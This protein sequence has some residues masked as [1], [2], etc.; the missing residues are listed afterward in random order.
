M[1]TNSPVKKLK[2][3]TCIIIAGPTA[4]GKTACAIQL[5]QHFKTQIISADSRQCFKELHIGVAKP[6]VEE[7]QAVPHHFI[8]SHS[9]QDEVNA[10]VFEQYAL[11]KVN[12]ILAVNDI[13]VLVGGTGLYIKAFCEG[14]D[15][16]P[17]ADAAVRRQ[18][19]DAY[20]QQGIE[21]LQQQVAR[22]D[23][24]FYARGETKNPQRLMRALEVVLTTGRS[25]TSY[26]TQQKK[27]REFNIVKIALE[28]PRELLYQNINYRVNQMVEQGLVAEVNSLLPFKKL[29]ALQT[30]GYKELFDYFEGITS[31]DAAIEKIKLNTRHYAKRQLTW[32]KKDAAWKWI[33]PQHPLSALLADISLER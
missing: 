10:A 24:L 16:V 11:Q 3:N 31:L 19:I 20:E 4:V 15:E 25:I 13:A 27:Q 7:L 26:Q 33:T 21:W 8:S 29:N 28:L 9:I 14:M 32:F 22:H 6:S 23:A 1:I 5:A 2:G 30:V 18:V 17:P 12:D